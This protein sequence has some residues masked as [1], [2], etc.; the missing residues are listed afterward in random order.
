VP[1]LLQ[2]KQHLRYVRDL[3]VV[4]AKCHAFLSW[5]T[6]DRGNLPTAEIHART[7]LTLAQEAGHLGAEALALSSLSKSAYW[8][9]RIPAAQLHAERAFEIAP[10]AP[11]RALL[12][13]QMAD[14]SPAPA[15]DAAIA[16]ASD[17]L[18]SRTGQDD[19]GGVFDCGRVRVANY[20]IS[21][22]GRSQVSQRESTIHLEVNT[23]EFGQL[24]VNKSCQGFPT[25]G[26]VSHGRCRGNQHYD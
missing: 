5:A 20:A 16:A 13:C 14:A 7:A 8:S 18:D 15:A 11:V 24:C 12:A 17:A 25:L 2:H 4:A 1:L 26:L 9:D 10:P 19:L 3:Y 23:C 6:G 22:C 21:A